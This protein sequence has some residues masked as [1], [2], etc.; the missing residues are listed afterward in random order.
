MSYIGIRILK[1]IEGKQMKVIVTRTYEPDDKESALNILTKQ[2][3]EAGPLKKNT[4]GM[5]FCHYEFVLSGTAE[6][7]AQNLPFPVIGSSTTLAGFSTDKESGDSYDKGQFRLVLVVI[8]GDDI[9]FTPVLSEPITPNLSADEICKNTFDNIGKQKLGII[10]LPHIIITDPEK[11]LDAVTACTNAQLFGGTAV[12][13]SPTYIENCFVIAN[14]KAYRDRVVTLFINGNIDPHFASIV[15]K[16]DEP[17][18]I[19]AIITES[20]G[21][22]IISIDG[23]P[24]T[25]FL[26]RNGLYLTES[27]AD[28][29][30]AAVM[31]VDDGD[32][33]TYGRSMMFLTPDDH[34]FV[35]GSVTTGATVS[36]E[37]FT[38]KNV[39]DASTFLTRKM[40][41]EY[42]DTHFA[43]VSSCES[44]HILLGS[45]TFDGENMLRRELGD[46]PFVL[47]YAGGEICPSPAST[48]EKPINRV[49]NQ[50]YCI[51]LI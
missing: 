4:Y 50:S 29:L 44:R 31:I 42:P 47:A 7:I 46:I 30:N 20:K 15:V 16:E 14:G 33:D 9:E 37:K 28:A 51:C 10:I 17:S 22:E 19:T 34:L 26:T 49:F 32:G 12:D 5:M 18:V 8:S 40:L 39:L 24:V 41:P 38:T 23:R 27:K 3:K 1:K 43:F 36:I 11:L 13:D 45:H 21:N 2:I 6:Y 35:G 25:E 48:P